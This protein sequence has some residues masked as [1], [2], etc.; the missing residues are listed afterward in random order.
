MHRILRLVAAALALLAV[1]CSRDSGE[2]AALPEPSMMPP[3]GIGPSGRFIFTFP[4]RPRPTLSWVQILFGNADPGAAPYCF[5]HIEPKGN[6]LKLYTGPGML[7]FTPPAAAGSA[8]GVL[9]ANS[10]RLDAA[11][12]SVANAQNGLRINLSL[13]FD[14]SMAGDRVVYWRTLDTDGQDS[15]WQRVGSWSVP[16]R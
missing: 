9:K 15:R 10:C 7:D 3:T 1:G 13:Q 6:L 14:P 2:P 11:A 12:S 5:V 16:A 8:F 4:D